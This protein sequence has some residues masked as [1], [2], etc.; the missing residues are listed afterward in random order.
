MFSVSFLLDELKHN[1]IDMHM[2]L[3]TI[4]VPRSN[5]IPRDNKGYNNSDER[6][7]NAE[8]RCY[9]NQSQNHL[10]NGDQRQFSCNSP[11]VTTVN[12]DKYS[13]THNKNYKG[14]V[15]Y[16]TDEQLEA[17][18]YDGQFGELDINNV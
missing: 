7:Y 2:C 15:Y 16:D 13:D 18:S 4:V 17:E 9:N 12:V 3:T 11:K 10:Q 1:V 8:G 14:Q 6:S 5:F